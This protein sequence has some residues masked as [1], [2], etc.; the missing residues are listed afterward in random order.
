MDKDNNKEVEFKVLRIMLGYYCKKH[1]GHNVNLCKECSDLLEYSQSK[2]EA[3]PYLH[4]KP[5]CRKCPCYCFNDE[6]KKKMQ[7]MMRSVGL[8]TLIFHPILTYQYYKRL[9]VV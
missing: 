6:Y 4:K 8:K 1:H 9:T 5:S 3:C 2:V 7:I